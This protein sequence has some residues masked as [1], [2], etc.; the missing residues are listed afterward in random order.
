MAARPTC[1]IVAAG[2]QPPGQWSVSGW[3]GLY[4]ISR[5]D[6]SVTWPGPAKAIARGT[7]TRWPAS[8]LRTRNSRPR[9]LAVAEIA[10]AGGLRRIHRPD[11][12]RSSAV[13]LEL[14]PLIG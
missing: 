5:H 7:G 13:S 2:G 6:R 3:P 4:S 12:A 8:A 11:G 9:S 14:P 1:P 10:A